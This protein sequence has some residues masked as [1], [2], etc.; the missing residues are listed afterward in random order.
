MFKYFLF[1]FLFVLSTFSQTDDKIK[2]KAQN[3]K[4]YFFGENH[5]V[6]EKYDEMKS[7]IFER[8]NSVSS[9]EKVTMFFELPFSF[10]YA[11]S[12]IKVE[13]DT[14]VFSDWFNH[15]Y[16]KKDKS[17]SYFW[18]DY[19]AFILALLEYAEIKGIDL[20]IICIDVE[21][22]LRRTAF[23]LSSFES[24]PNT[25]LDSLL[26]LDYIKNDSDT[27]TFLLDYV[28]QLSVITNNLYEL[29]ILDQLK[30]SLLIDCTICWKRDQ[31]MY[32]NFVKYYD[33]TDALIFGTFGIDHV[34]NNPEFSSINDFFR[35]N[36]KVDTIDHQSFYNSINEELK[37][38]IFRVGIIALNQK[39]KLSNMQKPRDYSYMMKEDERNYIRVLLKE[40]EVVR[41]FL[42][43][44]EELSNLSL[45]LDYL[46]VY[47]SSNFR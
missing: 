46:I 40:K 42:S 17:P 1:S 35:I 29:E 31:F 39:M 27:R 6:K 10:N 18:T 9:G 25:K 3:D 41:I 30:S 16:K 12:R 43:D 32:D 11:I 44:H 26:N 4:L 5:F 45:N 21:L 28:N 47:K 23:I 8:L 33:S 7:F 36:H 24:M 13:K 19:R 14:S 15:L 2:Q 37:N 20:Q 38:Q 34:I 22:E